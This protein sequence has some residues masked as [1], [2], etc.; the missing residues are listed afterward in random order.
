MRK[1]HTAA[2]ITALLGQAQEMA[3][4]GKLH[5]DI[6]KTLGVS[7]M[8]YHRWR[9]ARV[10]NC[11]NAAAAINRNVAIPRNQRKPVG[12]VY[13]ENSRLR[14]LVTDLLL[15]KIKL[16]ERLRESGAIHRMAARG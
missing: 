7:M 8:T 3:A 2:E 16:E 15:E 14:R 9:K 6:A 10:A 13:L 12:E 11:S 4:L 1:R 5:G